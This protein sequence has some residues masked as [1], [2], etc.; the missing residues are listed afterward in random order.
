MA[1]HF[2]LGFSSDHY[3]YLK[4]LLSHLSKT[5]LFC[6]YN[7]AQDRCHHYTLLHRT[8]YK[9]VAPQNTLPPGVFCVIIYLYGFKWSSSFAEYRD[10]LGAP[11][12][13]DFCHKRCLWKCSNYTS[14]SSNVSWQHTVFAVT[15]SLTRNQLL[16]IASSVDILLS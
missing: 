13:C 10:G 15:S 16:E 5:M 9:N 14:I 12:S 3:C 8:T 4:Y 7:L 6:K 11:V 1:P 2:C